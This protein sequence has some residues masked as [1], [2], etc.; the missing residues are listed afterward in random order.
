MGWNAERGG[1]DGIILRVSWHSVKGSL[2]LG[3][4]GCTS[5]YW[6]VYMYAI[7]QSDI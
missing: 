2:D 1:F 3:K 6:N 7:C 5:P 4:S